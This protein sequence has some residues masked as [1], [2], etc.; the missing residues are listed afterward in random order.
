MCQRLSICSN[1]PGHENPIHHVTQG[2]AQQLVNKMIETLLAQQ[3]TKALL[4]ERKFAS[5]INLLNDRIRAYEEEAG[6]GVNDAD[7]D[8]DGV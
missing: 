2:D 8:S 5:Q 3:A 1:V 7:D 6:I 4:L